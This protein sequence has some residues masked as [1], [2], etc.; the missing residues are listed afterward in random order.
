MREDLR[1]RIS[2]EKARLGKQRQEEA[3]LDRLAQAAGITPPPSLVEEQQQASLGAYAQ[4]LQQQGMPEE[5]IQQQLESSKEEAQKDAERR[6]QMFFL[7]EAVAQQQGLTV[8]QADLEAELESI[9][10]AN[11]TPEQQLTAGQVFAHLKE[12]NRI[13]ELQLSLLER[14]VREFLRENGQIVD[15]TGE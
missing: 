5:E 1:G 9:A 4:R 15:K 7:I 11:S 2:Q 14:K 8:E 10:Q 12:Q 6:V 13:G 3:A